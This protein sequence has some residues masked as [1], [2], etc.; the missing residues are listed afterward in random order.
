MDNINNNI[1]SSQDD[2]SLAFL[3]I[4]PDSSNRHYNCDE[5]T[6]QKLI[7]KSFYVIDF[8]DGVTT[9]FGEGRFLVKIKFSLTDDDDAA[10][11][12]FTNSQEIKYILLAIRERN[13]FPRRVTMK[14]SGTRYW[15]E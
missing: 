7:N 5:V 12:F 14:A 3:R 10:R 6:Q 11:K 2:G 1:N 13:A 8:M 4:P 9:K 15:I